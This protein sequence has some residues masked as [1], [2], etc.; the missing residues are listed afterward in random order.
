MASIFNRK[1][2]STTDKGQQQSQ[3]TQQQKAAQQQKAQQQVPKTY[4]AMRYRIEKIASK[5]EGLDLALKENGMKES[6]YEF[7]RRMLFASIIIG[8]VLGISIFALFFKAGLS[9]ALSVLLAIILGFMIGR[10]SFANFINYPIMKGK[11]S[12]KDV[13]KS[14]LFAARDMIISLRSG[15]PLFN[16]I[17][18]VSTGYGA[19]SKEFAKIVESVQLGKPLEQA[20]D[21]AVSRTKSSAFKRLMLQASVSI[22]AG[23]EVVNALQTILDQLS[24]E[25]VIEL[26]RYG[27]KLNAIAMFY[28]LF[29]VIMPSMGI[30][31]V[32]ILTTFISIF[33]VTGGV[34]VAVLV[35]LVFVQ[36]IFLR[37]IVASRPVFSM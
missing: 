8:I 34:L 28:M 32:T 9:I 2:D 10:V 1:K 21:D 25:R 29:G 20:M 16:A 37:V 17:A 11:R 30:A 27:Q 18:S 3:P 13:D 22:K 23:G 19:A 31:V 7:I 24:Q 6:P 5:K 12:A 14:I 4:G 26:R 33:S 36:I 15:M 35:F